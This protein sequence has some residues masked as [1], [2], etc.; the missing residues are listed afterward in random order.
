MKYIIWI[1]VSA[2]LFGISFDFLLNHK[3]NIY[4]LLISSFSSLILSAFLGFMYL[5]FHGI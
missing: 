2:L 1:L 3:K 5:C 4:W